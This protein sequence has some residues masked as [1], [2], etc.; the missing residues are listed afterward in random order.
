MEPTT[1]NQSLRDHDLPIYP[2][3]MSDVLMKET[4]AEFITRLDRVRCSRCLEILPLSK[5]HR[6]K[7][8]STGVH[9]QCKRCRR[10]G[11]T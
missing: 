9:S 5:F 11:G 8:G 10:E 2:L 6:V 3:K 7:M 4:R 1:I